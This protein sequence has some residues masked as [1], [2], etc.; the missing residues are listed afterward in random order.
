M[1]RVMCK[2]KLHRVKIKKVDLHYEGSIGIDKALMKAS[3]IIPYEMVHVLNVTNGARFETYAIE[4][5]SGSGMIALYGAAAHLGRAGD[6]LIILSYGTFDESESASVRARCIHVNGSNAI[7][8][9][10]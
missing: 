6:I 9:K 7:V 1:M 10:K 8:K 3:D 5:R 4:E 2:S